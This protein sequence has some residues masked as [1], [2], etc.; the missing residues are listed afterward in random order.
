MD[1]TR[2]SA[3]HSACTIKCIVLIRDMWIKKP[4]L[5]TYSHCKNIAVQNFKKSLAKFWNQG[6]VDNEENKI[7]KNNRSRDFL[8][9]QNPKTETLFQIRDG[10]RVKNPIET[11]TWP[12]KW[13]GKIIFY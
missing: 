2:S 9:K 7:E 1:Y 12:D 6:Y 4:E 3:K 13:N 8:I 10:S 5:F 11:V